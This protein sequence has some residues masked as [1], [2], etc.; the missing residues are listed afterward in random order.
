M[1]LS[2]LL[3]AFVAAVL[4]V[5]VAPVL[6]RVAWDMEMRKRGFWWHVVGKKRRK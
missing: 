2:D 1:T 6:V 5:V 4:L 3:Q